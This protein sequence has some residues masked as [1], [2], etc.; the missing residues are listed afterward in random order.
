MAQSLYIQSIEKW[1][2]GLM[3]KTSIQPTN[4]LRL[5][6]NQTS[7]AANTKLLNKNVFEKIF[8]LIS[9]NE[10][11]GLQINT[12]LISKIPLFFFFRSNW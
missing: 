2:D 3:W 12:K 4:D 6:F 9:A 5:R 7:A 1:C 11:Y 8:Q 10:F